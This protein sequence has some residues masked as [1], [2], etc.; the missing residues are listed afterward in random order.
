M[1]VDYSRVSIQKQLQKTKLLVTVDQI[2]KLFVRLTKDTFEFDNVVY[3]YEHID[4]AMK[5]RHINKLLAA[6]IVSGRPLGNVWSHLFI[7]KKDNEYGI[8][9][10][11]D[12][13]WNKYPTVMSYSGYRYDMLVIA[14]RIKES[15][16]AATWI[17]SSSLL[18]AVDIQHSPDGDKK[19]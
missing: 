1:R 16:Y 18:P 15:N 11:S 7:Y 9:V 6:K 17:N 10:T 3:K 4:T 13:H 2:L 14:E 12:K 8:V 19:S 5:R